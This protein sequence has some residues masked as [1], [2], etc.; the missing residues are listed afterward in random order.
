MAPSWCRGTW[1]YRERSGFTNVA[2]RNAWTLDSLARSTAEIGFK[3]ERN[4]WHE[5][6]NH[7]N[8]VRTRLNA[9]KTVP[10]DEPGNAAIRSLQAL[11]AD[12]KQ[13][14]EGA[15]A[16]NQTQVNSGKHTRGIGS[17][18]NGMIGGI[19]VADPIRV[20]ASVINEVRAGAKAVHA[21]LGEQLAKLRGA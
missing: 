20:E 1:R 10:G 5:L 14:H 4:G 11:D 9:L 6:G 7:A 21:S 3:S 13:V 17:V 18:G 2:T 19:R 8:L 15:Y 12:L 16:I